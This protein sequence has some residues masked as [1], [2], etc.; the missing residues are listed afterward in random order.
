[1]ENTEKNKIYAKSVIMK[2]LES[3]D[4]S[5]SESDVE[6]ISVL[7][8]KPSIQFEDYASDDEVKFV[9][10]NKTSMSPVRMLLLNW[11][12]LYPQN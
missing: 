10:V 7:P 6:I 12:K 1:M 2:G 5:S 11:D 3:S 8:R 9:G 4:Y